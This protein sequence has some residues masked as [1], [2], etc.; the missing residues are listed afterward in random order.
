MM[1]EPFYNQYQRS[2]Q[3]ALEAIA[4][5]YNVVL[6]GKGGNGKTRLTNELIQEGHLDITQYRIMSL[7]YESNY[8]NKQ[9]YWIECNH[10]DYAMKVLQHESF[11]VIN[12][13]GFVHPDYKNRTDHPTRENTP[14]YYGNVIDAYGHC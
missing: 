10:F 4:H 6:F 7:E 9:K 14:W 2:K 11:F 8:S 3:Y 5:N 12:M 1:E 13:N